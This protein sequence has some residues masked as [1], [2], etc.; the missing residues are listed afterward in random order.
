MSEENEDP[1]NKPYGQYTE[2]DVL[3]VEY[4]HYYVQVGGDIFSR[5][6]KMAFTRAR[7]EHFYDGILKDLN[8]IKETGTRREKED[9]KSCLLWLRIIPMR[10]H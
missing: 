8:D 2:E 9:A 6:G 1:K 5:D 10:V 7:A 4:G 3:M